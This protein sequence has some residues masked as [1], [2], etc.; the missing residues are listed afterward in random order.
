MKGDTTLEQLSGFK[1]KSAWA[2][3]FCVSQGACSDVLLLPKNYYIILFA[4]RLGYSC[5]YIQ[6]SSQVGYQMHTLHNQ[7]KAFIG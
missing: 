1:L 3:E 2:S 6:Q 5:L 7:N 4:K